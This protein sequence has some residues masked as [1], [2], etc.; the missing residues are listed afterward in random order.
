MPRADGLQSMELTI[1]EINSVA[2]N[3][4]VAECVKLWNRDLLNINL[5]V[6]YKAEKCLLC[7]MPIGSS[8]FLLEC[9]NLRIIKDLL[10]KEG[11]VECTAV[12][13]YANSAA[14]L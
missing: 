7:E 2:R 12:E 8:H 3:E 5:S 4:E 9:S 10:R 6:R 1:E 11:I 14:F 13:R